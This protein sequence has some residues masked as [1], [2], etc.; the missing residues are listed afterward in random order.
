MNKFVQFVPIPV[1]V[2]FLAFLWMIIANQ[3][4]LLGWV[5]F[6]TW[7]GFFLAGISSRSAYREAIS[8]TLG[9]GVAWLIVLVGTALTPSLGTYAFPV[10]VGIA[11]F[12][13]VLLELVPWFDMAPG[14]FLG[15]A[16][17]FAAMKPDA[18]NYAT[19]LVVLIPGILGL[20]F[21]ILT[22]YLRGMVFSAEGKTDPLTK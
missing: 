13:I 18:T 14:Y 21:G 3:F 15:A 16:A 1:I 10:V 17:F 7:G 6:I 5:A 19:F 12:F 8:F 4:N 2:G 9:L 20:G 11:A 22:G